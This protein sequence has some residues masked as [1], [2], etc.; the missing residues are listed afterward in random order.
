MDAKQ[1]AVQRALTLGRGTDPRALP[2]LIA[3]TRHPYSEV[4]RLA[5]SAI[6]KLAAFGANPAD[7]VPA[8]GTLM[9]GD[10]HPQ[11]RQYAIKALQHFGQAAT[12][13]VHDLD[14]LRRGGAAL[15][16]CVAEILRVDGVTSHGQR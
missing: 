8:V 10:P 12:S 15:I 1:Q 3:L 14:D 16:S 9:L 7:A 2:E 11:V 4:R 5:A 6:G 13:F